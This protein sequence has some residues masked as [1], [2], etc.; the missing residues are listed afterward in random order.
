[1]RLR[2]LLKS[3]SFDRIVPFIK[4]SDQP[5]DVCHYKQAYD[6]LLH[7]TAAEDGCSD[8]EVSKREDYD[9]T[10]YISASQI[11]GCAWS[12]YIDGEVILEDGID[13]PN[14]EL[15]FKLLWHLT[16][17]GYSQE[18]S[19][20]NIEEMSNDDFHD[21]E[22]GLMARAIEH[23]RYMLWANKEIKKRIREA[24]RWYAEQGMTSFGLSEEDWRYLDKREKHCNRMKRMR[25][26][27][28]EKRQ[29]HLA[30]LDRCEN[31]VQRL[32]EGQSFTHISRQDLAFLFESKERIGTEF[33]TRA[34]DATKRLEYLKEL[35][36]NY[37]ALTIADLMNRAVIKIS[38]SADSPLT[39]EEEEYI[40]KIMTE[41]CGKQ[42]LI[43]IKAFQDTLGSEI[44]I[45]AV[46]TK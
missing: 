33:Q 46:G 23:K 20:A 3:V 36:S 5:D 7:T 38:T 32:L 9:G 29:E 17:Y 44:A 43:V 22:Y 35:V 4:Q 24:I 31:T 30:N 25:D 40:K 10:K 13:V 42:N 39:K 12:R 27:R 15:A 37:E 26:H 19:T 11:E 18:E 28:L 41:L 2:Q 14:E 16:F 1:M 45:M 21:T 34:Y 8:I 6:I